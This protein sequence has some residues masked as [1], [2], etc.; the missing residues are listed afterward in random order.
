MKTAGLL[1]ALT[2]AAY[3]KQRIFN[4]AEKAL[5]N[6]EANI[7]RKIRILV[8]PAL[9]SCLLHKTYAAFEKTVLIK[10]PV[11]EACSLRACIFV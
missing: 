11:G 1:L 2:A 6:P 3:T 7:K 9:C 8:L 10:T 5:Q 4:M